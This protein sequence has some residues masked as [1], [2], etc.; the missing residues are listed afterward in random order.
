MLP[1][2]LKL[3]IVVD[4]LVVL[5]LMSGIAKDGLEAQFDPSHPAFGCTP[6]RSLPANLSLFGCMAYCYILSSII[7]V[8]TLLRLAQEAVAWYQ[9]RRRLQQFI[10]PSM[11]LVFVEHL[12]Q[13]T[14]QIPNIAPLPS[15]AV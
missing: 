7:V 11:D 15:T 1:P 5:Q 10:F 13:C 12:N 9:G 3:L 2:L 14:K 6:R 8:Y 4:L